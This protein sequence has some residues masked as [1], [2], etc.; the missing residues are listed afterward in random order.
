VVV[1]NSALVVVLRSIWALAAP[2]QAV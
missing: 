1:Q 2:S